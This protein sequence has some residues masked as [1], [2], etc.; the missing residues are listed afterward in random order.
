MMASVIIGWVLLGFVL[1]IISYILIY[2]QFKP[3]QLKQKSPTLR[4][5][6]LLFDDRYGLCKVNGGE[7][8]GSDSFTLDITSDNGQNYNLKYFR[9]E[10]IP[11]N[12]YNVLVGSGSPLYITRKA[13]DLME[14]KPVTQH[15]VVKNLR[16]QMQTIKSQA[17]IQINNPDEKVKQMVDL[18][19]QIESSK[20]AKEVRT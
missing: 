8:L 2:P 20:K 7:R 10:I 1:L 19:S 16:N 13:F 9:G 17:K 14:G 6:P 11:Y 18:I 15:D 5:S 4:A 12:E 3:N